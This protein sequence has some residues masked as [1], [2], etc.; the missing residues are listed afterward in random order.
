MFANNVGGIPNNNMSN[1]DKLSES[2]EKWLING[3]EKTAASF[4]NNVVILTNL[5]RDRTLS[6]PEI[7]TFMEACGI[8]PDKNFGFNVNANIVSA[9]KERDYNSVA[10]FFTFKK[11]NS[12]PIQD[13]QAQALTSLKDT[14]K[15]NA[16]Q[17]VGSNNNRD[18]LTALILDQ[19][20]SDQNVLSFLNEIGVRPEGGWF[21]TKQGLPTNLKS[22]LQAERPRVHQTFFEAKQ[23]QPVVAPAAVQAH[24]PAQAPAAAPAQAAA[25]A[26]APLLKT[27]EIDLDFLKTVW[28]SNAIQPGGT[29]NN[30]DLL[31]TLISDQNYSDQN[32]LT[33]LKEIGVRPEGGWFQT[34][35]GLPTNLKTHLQAE[36]P[37]VH[38]TF[39]EAKQAQP[40]VTPAAAPVQAPVQ[41]Q[42]AAPAKVQAAAQAPAPVPP[43]VAPVIPLQ[44][45]KIDPDFTT[46]MSIEGQ[47]AAHETAKKYLE[48]NIQAMN[49]DVFIV[50]P[51]KSK[52]KKNN[53]YTQPIGDVDTSIIFWE[54]TQ[55][56]QGDIQRDGKVK[57]RLVLYGVASQFNGSEA[58]RRLTVPPGQAVNAYAS[59]NT[60]GPGAQLQFPNEQVEIINDAANLGFNGL[61]NVLDETTKDC[62]KHGYLTPMTEASADAVIA[63]LKEKGHLLEFPCIGN[64]PKGADNTEKVYEMLVAAPAFGMYARGVKLTDE[65]KQELTFLCAV[66]AYRAQFAQTL[67]L[68]K[69]NPGKEVIF[70]PTAPGLGVFGNEAEFVCK[71]F[72]VAA[73]EFE[74]E[75]RNHGV[76]VALQVFRGMQPASIIKDTLGL[77]EIN[78]SI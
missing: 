5:I 66:N 75:F 67:E 40:V 4:Q 69:L 54:N 48:D 52:N 15:S 50:S 13:P 72:A 53:D 26:P 37:N 58:V 23:A 12:P 77:Q 45:E 51:P 16:T 1:A 18:L 28:K 14:W 78:T 64:I 74:T 24:A 36:R 59:D 8:N 22:L 43:V 7:R 21:Q 2:L 46:N 44:V 71:G 20:F 9:L 55:G 73:R 31:K 17:Q 32:V 39:F 34:K 57:N 56:V 65:Q 6:D 70:K 10:D 30:R 49:G 25:Q 61:C 35:Q 38:Q 60:Q 62:V 63:Q 19:N 29:Q 68:A 76:K 47:R 33:F 42:A 3:N 11:S 27:Q 41:A